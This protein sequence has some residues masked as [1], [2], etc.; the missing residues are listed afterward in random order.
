[1]KTAPIKVGAK[2]KSTRAQITLTYRRPED[3]ADCLAICGAPAEAVELVRQMLGDSA[4]DTF[5]RAVAS[6]FNRGYTIWLQDRFGRPMFEQGESAEAIQAAFDSGIPGQ[7]K[8]VARATA[9][10]VITPSDY[11]ALEAAAAKGDK[12][13]MQAILAQYGVKAVV[14]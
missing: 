6:L 14:E 1:M 8:G 10:K 12:S 9:P 11:A 5:Q 4:F 3:V 13:R 7:T 2:S